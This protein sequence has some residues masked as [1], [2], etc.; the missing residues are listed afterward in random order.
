MKLQKVKSK[1]HGIANNVRWYIGN[2][3]I[4]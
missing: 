1:R 3:R 4:H 2:K